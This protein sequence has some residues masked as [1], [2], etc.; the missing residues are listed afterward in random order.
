MSRNSIIAGALL[1]WAFVEYIVGSSNV[2][3]PSEAAVNVKDQLIVD[4]IVK[5]DQGMPKEPTEEAKRFYEKVEQERVDAAKV[6]DT[7]TIQERIAQ[8]KAEGAKAL[9]EFDNAIRENVES[10]RKA[11][12]KAAVRHE[13]LNSPGPKI[14]DS[15]V[16]KD[17]RVQGNRA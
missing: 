5:N 14:I 2:T 11:L 16:M 9:E 7:R 13:R 12:K 8:N 15:Y 10:R 17:G 3:M 4:Q 1:V 6:K